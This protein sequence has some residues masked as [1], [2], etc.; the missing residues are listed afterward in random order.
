MDKETVFFSSLVIML[1][2]EIGY[3]MMNLTTVWMLGVGVITTILTIGLTVGIVAGISALT[4]GM[5]DTSVRIAFMASTII[6]VLF[7][8]E[9]PLSWFGI[10][11]D[12]IKFFFGFDTIPMGIGLLYPNLTSIFIVTGNDILSIFG[13]MIVSSLMLITIVSGLMIAAG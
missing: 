1:I 2:F 11:G 12:T 8:F 4:V 5:N 10:V 13:L 3:Y 6:G 9:I 7:R